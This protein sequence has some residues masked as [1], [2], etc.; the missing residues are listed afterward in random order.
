[1]KEWNE[2]PYFVIHDE[3]TY[4]GP[5]L[6]IWD[7]LETNKDE[8]ELEDWLRRDN[9]A[10]LGDATET[11]NYGGVFRYDCEDKSLCLS[12][13]N[14]EACRCVRAAFNKPSEWR[15]YKDGIE[16]KIFQALEINDEIHKN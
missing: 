9:V 14:A 13:H 16:Q 5:D 3:A 6:A 11:T 7:V 1:M 2:Y 12:Y 8:K 4:E 15:A 10:E